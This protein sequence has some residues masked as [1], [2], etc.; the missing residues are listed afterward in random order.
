MYE[1]TDIII[2]GAGLVGLSFACLMAQQGRT[3]R[4]LETHLPDILTQSRANHRPLALSYGSYRTLTSL[5]IWEAIQAHASPLLAVHVS[6]EGRLGFTK[7]TAR[8]M[9]KEA[10]GY[11]VPLSEL[12]RALYTR[13][14]SLKK[15]FYT[16]ISHIKKIDQKKIVCDQKTYESDLFVAADGTQSACRTMLNIIAD[17]N[18][19]GETAIIYQVSLDKPHDFVAYER[20][21]EAGVFALLPLKNPHQA[22]IVQTGKNNNDIDDKKIQDVFA[23]RITITS[24]KKIA[25]YPLKTVIA[26]QQVVGTAVLLGNSA[27]TIY[28]VAAQGFNLGLHDAAMLADLLL[29]NFT[30]IPE[31]LLAYE[32]KVRPHQQKI[33]R[34]TGQLSTW[35]ELP[36]LG[37]ARGLG[38]MLLNG[39]GVLKRRIA[40]EMMG[41]S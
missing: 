12:Y 35:F 13:A 19:W 31:V 1:K 29:K 25:E 6:Q 33:I 37:R 23:G 28:P 27:H 38:M 30:H 26:R 11:V 18:A 36:F 34:F 3:V 14:A 22:Q 4:L 17:E 10:L 39:S 2:A 7:F 20:F 24:V 21:T 5:T 40:R 15:V 41:I 9:Q 8:E 32:K 16:G